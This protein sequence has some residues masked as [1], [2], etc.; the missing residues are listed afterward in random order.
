[1]T[2][3][4]DDIDR[5]DGE[6][7]PDDERDLDDERF[8][9]DERD[10][11][12][13]AWAWPAAGYPPPPPAGRW[14]ARRRP[15]VLIVTAV[16]AAAAGFGMVAAALHD[17]SGSPAS[18]SSTPST[19][20]SSPSGGQTMLPP[21]S[22]S[23]SGGAI[24]TPGPGQQLELE[25]GGPVTKVSTTSITIGMGDRAVTAAVTKAT[26][27]TGKVSSIAGIK[28]GELVS[29]TITGANGKLTADSI[30]DPASLP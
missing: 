16:V 8:P 21:Q 30:Q 18:A 15:V 13:Q 19:G 2:A 11:D 27:I 24:P 14:E 29:A 12:G 1:M 3:D 26:K 22:G 10:D 6:P 17:V 5:L 4:D 28:V 20:A 9:D 25:V 7:E 23:G